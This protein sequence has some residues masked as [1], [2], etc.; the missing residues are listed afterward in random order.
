MRMCQF[1]TVGITTNLATPPAPCH[2][3]RTMEAF[4]DT[5]YAAYRILTQVL[6]RRQSLDGVLE[7]DE[8]LARFST[9]DRGFVRLLTATV[10]RRLGTLDHAIEGALTIPDLDP[11]ARHV[12]R[13][14][15]VQLRYLHTP[16][17][18]AI[19]TAVDLAQNVCPRLKGFVN[20]VLRR[21]A[22]LT[23]DESPSAALPAG[24]FRRWV[25]AYGE[26][27]AAAIA[28]A[29][30]EEPPLDITVKADPDGWAARLGATVMPLGTLRRDV[31]TVHA[32]PGFA[33]GEWWVQ[34]LAASLPVKLMGDLAGRT[35][36][37]LCAAPGGKTAQ[38]AAAGAQVT[39]VDRSPQRLKRLKENMARLRLQVATVDADAV[40]WQ[41]PPADAV[42]LDAPCLATGTIRRHPDIPWQKSAQDL[43]SLAALQSRL[44]DR[45]SMRV[46]PGG[47]L[48]Y[49]TCS[50]EPEEGERQVEAF[51]AR[52]AGFR[53]NPIATV[54]LPGLEMLLTS[55]GDLR[56]LPCTLTEQGGMDGFYVARLA[57]PSRD[58]VALSL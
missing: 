54:E 49:C 3:I 57:A 42:L 38:L 5:R 25:A 30:R 28:L 51:L 1:V 4:S 12:L 17:H 58:G 33:E 22:D 18:A 11:S 39:A 47:M 48:V 53:R 7:A 14:G 35:V 52:N 16:P 19:S 13:I 36:Y 24:L 55:E 31:E 15:L 40:L 8:V 41:A 32:L 21:H 44:L 20:A 43:E 10:L 46:K 50:L 26:D 9:R 56:A 29:L 37:D 6:D 23:W 2:L 27:R 34:D 45:A